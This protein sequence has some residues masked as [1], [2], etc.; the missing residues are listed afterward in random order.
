MTY[1]HS[2]NYSLIGKNKKPETKIDLSGIEEIKEEIL[3]VLKKDLE[4]WEI[5]NQKQM[6]VEK[7]NL[8]SK[9]LSVL[10]A[11]SN[12]FYAALD[13]LEVEQKIIPEVIDSKVRYIL[14]VIKN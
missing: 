11:S 7:F 4:F 10:P 12:A 5:C 8:L 13:E 1:T 14:F 2:S 6:G 9:V 3:S